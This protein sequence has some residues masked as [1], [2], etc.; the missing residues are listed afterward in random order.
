MQSTIT[1]PNGAKITTKVT[2]DARGV[3]HVAVVSN[4]RA[5]MLGVF[6]VTKESK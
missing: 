3:A 6:E 1:L 4:G 2:L 5:L